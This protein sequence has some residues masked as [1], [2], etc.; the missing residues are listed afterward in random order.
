MGA[1]EEEG[2]RCEASDCKRREA[3]EESFS[4]A[5]QNEATEE[6][7]AMIS[8]AFALSALV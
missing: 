7:D 2:A 1:G 3:A 4:I 6:T 8:A 5:I